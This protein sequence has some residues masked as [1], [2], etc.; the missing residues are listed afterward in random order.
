MRRRLSSLLI[1]LI[2]SGAGCS[3][4]RERPPAPNPGAACESSD[5]CVELACVADARWPGGYCSSYCD[6]GTCV[7]GSRCIEGFGTRPLCLAECTSDGDCR[8]GYQCWA[9]VCRPTCLSDSE[10][11]AAGAACVDGRCT[12][13]E[14]AIDSDCGAALRCLGGRCVDAPADAGG[15]TLPDG[16][17]CGGPTE[18]ASGICLPPAQGGVCAAPCTDR[19]S[20]VDFDLACA[21]VAL[22]VDGDGAG[23]TVVSACVPADPAGQ[24]LA[25]YCRNDSDCESRVCLR[26]QCQ[27]SCD[28]DTDCLAGQVCRD[29][30]YPGIEGTTYRGCW[31][32]DRSGASQVVD[33]A[34]DTIGVN[35]GLPSSRVSFAIPNDA[36]SVTLMARYVS[37]DALPLAFIDVWDPASAH[38]FDYGELVSWVDQPIRWIPINSE[39]HIDML[40][41]NS[42]PDR[43]TFRHGRY[44]FTVAGL[45][46]GGDVGT[47]T[48]ELAARV[49]RAAGGDVTAGTLELNV[50]L[51]GVGLTAST[52][53]TH[54]RLQNALTELDRILGGAGIGVGAVDY[55]QITGTDAT[56]YGVID[57]S[58][59]PTSEMARLLRLS[60]DRSNAAV[61][62]FLVRSISEGAGESGGIALG[63]AGGIP[64]P[65]GVHGT[66]HS[67]VLVSFDT[68]V[69]GT[70]HRVV[71]QIMAH[72]ISHYLGLYHSRERAR[73]CADGTGPTETNPCA[74][75]GGGDPI[76]DT[77]RSDGRNLMWYALGG[78][79]GSTYN[80]GLSE[81]Q[82][83]VLR[84]S[85]VVQ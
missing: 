29:V 2:V 72:E 56:T 20:C 70:D 45:G 16:S 8:E 28:D 22:D 15:G 17:P 10:C 73:P 5:E 12:G 53:R 46:D 7:E 77:S 41:P 49:K 6:E 85:A 42:T 34:L 24:F 67:G 84:R 39:D 60:A 81:G 51:V 61:N 47:A 40:V 19:E 27:E 80:I 37:G 68:S 82:G 74:P 43:V 57:S 55:I 14:C 54:T 33:V 25:G 21:P 48:V 64:G 23:D 79:D 44:G 13:A 50:F 71:A 3:E 11:G 78:S 65:P 58:D 75:F 1:A 36:V 30:G 4:S 52:A 83:Y 62:V 76:A 63:I 66:S 26:S 31:Y 9:G 35:T 18:C 59:G 32:A 69:V 38:L